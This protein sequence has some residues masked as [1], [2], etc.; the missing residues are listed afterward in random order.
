MNAYPIASLLNLPKSSPPLPDLRAQLVRD[1]RHLLEKLHRS[2]ADFFRPTGSGKRLVPE[3]V[4]SSHLALG[5]ELLGWRCEREAQRAAGRTDLLVRR[6]GGDET[7]VVEVK[8]WRRNDDRQAHRQVESYWTAD[9]VAGAA[10]ALTDA[11]V[12][13]WPDRYRQ[14]CLAPLGLSAE[15]KPV[16]DSP[17]TAHFEVGSTTADGIAVSVDHLLLRLPR[18][19]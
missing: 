9:V 18:R 3:S 15:A 17:L 16:A 2:S 6:N 19:D 4:F 1:L 7:A 13:E 8:I 10:V 11:V 5:L 12:D 14:E